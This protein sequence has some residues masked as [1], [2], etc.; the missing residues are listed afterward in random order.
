MRNTCMLLFIKSYNIKYIEINHQ[1]NHQIILLLQK[2][3]GL[4]LWC[5][6]PPSTIF[7]LYRGGQF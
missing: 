3:L 2:G 7:Q 6:T 1:I 4:G 5:F